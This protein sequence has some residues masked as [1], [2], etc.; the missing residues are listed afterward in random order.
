MPKR[1]RE[2]RAPVLRRG[3][4]E[5]GQTTW[6]LADDRDTTVDE[7]EHCDDEDP[8]GH[9]DQRRRETRRE[10]AQRHEQHDGADAQGQCQPVDLI[11]PGEHVAQ[12][13]EEPAAVDGDP[14]QLAELPRD[15]HQPGACLEA[16]EDR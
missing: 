5:A 1:A 13:L 8:H 4:L 11:Q 14:R 6:H 3:E 9:A 10:S 7:V 12:V 16:G 2:Q 15:D